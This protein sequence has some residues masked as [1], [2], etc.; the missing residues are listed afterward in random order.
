MC[1][2]SSRLLPT[3][4]VGAMSRS[5][6]ARSTGW[7]SN[8]P[9]YGERASWQRGP[10]SSAPVCGARKALWCTPSAFHVTT[11]KIAATSRNIRAFSVG[12][13]EQ[14]WAPGGKIGTPRHGVARFPPLGS[15]QTN[16]GPSLAISRSELLGK[17]RTDRSQGLICGGK[18]DDAADEA[19]RHAEPYVELGVD[20]W[21]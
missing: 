16:I 11:A 18:G 6:I 7:V 9:H 8:W 12:S 5:C 21:F 2:V 10:Q 17:K 3:M 20:T 19:L 1:S 15:Q 4:A 13:T 14:M